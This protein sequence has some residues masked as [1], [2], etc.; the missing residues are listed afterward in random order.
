MHLAIAVAVGDVEVA[1]RTDGDV[2]RPI[3]RAARPRDRA[4]VLAVVAG[5]GR[6]V[7]GAEREEQ[8]ALRRELPDRVVTVVRA[9]DGVVRSH[10][11]A[12]RPEREVSLAPR[13]EEA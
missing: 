2:G 3:E 1:L 4:R 13:A 8:L 7:H 11:D 9:E 5:V 6:L 12:V 10:A